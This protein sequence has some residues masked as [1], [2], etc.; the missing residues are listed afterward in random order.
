MW[1]GDDIKVVEEEIHNTS[2]ILNTWSKDPTKMAVLRAMD[3]CLARFGH[4]SIFDNVI[5]DALAQKSVCFLHSYSLEV[6][7]V[8][9]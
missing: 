3:F 9:Y 7:E 5:V 2:L 1:S 6:K 4:Y 8:H